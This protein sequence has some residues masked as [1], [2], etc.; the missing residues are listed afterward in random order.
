MFRI[1]DIAAKSGTAVYCVDNIGRVWVRDTT[2]KWDTPTN[3]SNVVGVTTNKHATLCLNGRGEIFY[4]ETATTW[5]QTGLP[6]AKHIHL[7]PQVSNSV[8]F[9][10]TLGAIKHW[11][12]PTEEPDPKGIAVTVS[13]NGPDIAYCI[14]MT[15]DLF[16]LRVAGANKDWILWADAGKALSVDVFDGKDCWMVKA[17]QSLARFQG[18]AS[19]TPPGVSTGKAIQVSAVSADEI[20][21]VNAQGELWHWTV[22]SGW[23]KD[24]P[25]VLVGTIYVV[26]PGDTLSAIAQHFGKTV[27]EIVTATN[28]AYPQTSFIANPDFIWPGMILLI[29]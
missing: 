22:P 3:G 15:N 8:W 27:E 1:V 17:D 16:Y 18:G 9:V 20:W 25:P 26:Q 21:C 14:N 12:G 24:M 29:P 6:H 13:G 4:L 10:D 11:S 23:V 28:Q 2:G 19:T 7:S 5:W